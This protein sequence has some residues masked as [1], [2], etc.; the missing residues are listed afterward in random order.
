MALNSIS[1]LFALVSHMKR[2]KQILYQHSTCKSLFIILRNTSTHHYTNT[3]LIIIMYI[4]CM[5]NYHNWPVFPFLS[6]EPKDLDTSSQGSESHPAPS[7]TQQS[8]DNLRLL[9]TIQSELS[10]MNRRIVHLIFLPAALLLYLYVL[11]FCTG[12]FFFYRSICPC[13]HDHSC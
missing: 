8:S 13:M 6:P 2:L 4:L 10:D 11:L 3:M 12:L 9:R 7:N 5:T 1:L